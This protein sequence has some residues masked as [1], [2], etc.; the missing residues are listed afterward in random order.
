MTD[1]VQND[2]TTGATGLATDDHPHSGIASEGWSTPQADLATPHTQFAKIV[3]KR[4]GAETDVEFP[5]NPPAMVGR[6]DP[7]VGPI[8][9]DLGT[10]PEG[11]F[12][13]RKHARFSYEDGVWR[14]HDLGSSNGTWV[15]NSDFERVEEA[16]LHDGQ[17]IAFGNARFIF[18]ITAAETPLAADPQ[19]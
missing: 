4:N 9:I 6:F 14:V 12:V 11:S 1:D 13:S 18:K 7:T 8:D 10:L 17:E 5:V 19:S 15:L 16:P 2:L 3:L